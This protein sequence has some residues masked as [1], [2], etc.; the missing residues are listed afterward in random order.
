MATTTR[1]DNFESKLYRRI[2]QALEVALCSMPQDRA[3]F[4]LGELQA[5][6]GEYVLSHDRSTFAVAW[7]GAVIAT[8]EVA[9]LWGPK[10]QQEVVDR[11]RRPLADHLATRVAQ[12]PEE[13]QLAT[14]DALGDS[15]RRRGGVEGDDYVV[16]ID[17]LEF[18]RIPIKELLT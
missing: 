7:S 13:S 12:L 18:I 10:Y 3:R 16:L 14:I 2:Q 15:S 6:R 11:G 4:L 9:D 17:G 5:G 1:V 8:A